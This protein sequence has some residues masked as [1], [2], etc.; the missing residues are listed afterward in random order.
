MLPALQGSQACWSLGHPHFFGDRR[1]LAPLRSP[2]VS[3][4]CG[5]RDQPQ[6]TGALVGHAAGVSQASLC[7][8][9]PFSL[10]FPVRESESASPPVP[11]GEWRMWRGG[12][13]AAASP[14]LCGFLPVLLPLEGGMGGQGLE[15]PAGPRVT[16]VPGSLSRD[17]VASPCSQRLLPAWEGVVGECGSE[18]W[19]VPGGL[20]PAGLAGAVVALSLSMVFLLPCVI[21]WAGP[22][23]DRAAWLCST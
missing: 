23:A 8:Y 15:L 14:E 3:C 18:C 7:C 5:V 6:P 20:W 10:L 16:L 19:A 11:G 21:S 13:F 1:R 2:S 4:G 12:P 22:G 9:F 17:L